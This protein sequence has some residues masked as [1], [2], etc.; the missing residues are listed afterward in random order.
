MSMSSLESSI[1]SEARWVLENRTLRVKDLIEWSTSEIVPTS[2]ANG[3]PQPEEITVRLPL[4][5]VYVT[6]LKSHDKRK[7][8]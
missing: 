2:V 6:V 7:P 1:C 3:D 4:S 8:T 5:G